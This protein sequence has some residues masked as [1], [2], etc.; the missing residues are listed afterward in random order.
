MLL[1]PRLEEL[2]PEGHLIRVVNEMIEGLDI[3]PLK[4]QYK[5]GGTSAYH[6]KMVLK[7]IIYAYTQRIFSSRRI[8]KEL[9]ENVNYM[10]LSGMT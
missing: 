1:P 2:I 7:V 6:P 8:A 9:R 3:E 4:R 10:W 5:G